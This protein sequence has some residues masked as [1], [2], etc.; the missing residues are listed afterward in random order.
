MA[1]LFT[2]YG[3]LEHLPLV[4]QLHSTH[5]SSVFV[6]ESPPCLQFSPEYVWKI[7]DAIALLGCPPPAAFWA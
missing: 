2:L 6:A 7:L 4:K 5:G 3:S 1:K